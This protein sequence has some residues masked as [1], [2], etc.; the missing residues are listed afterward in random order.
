M[1]VITMWQPWASLLACGAKQYETRSWATNY[2][3]PI[4]IH[5]G[6]RNP[7]K[8]ITQISL[9][10]SAYEALGRT[11]FSDL[12]R[13]AVIAM[14]EL[15]GC[16]LIGVDAMGTYIAPKS[17]ATGIYVKSVYI[18]NENELLFGDWMPGRYAWEFANM[19]MLPEPIPARGYQGLWNWEGNI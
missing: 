15:V 4:A 16:H 10:N 8:A 7:C 14:A 2:R 13:G 6:L 3:G 9:M 5:A 1:K 17:E 12:P 18:K 11:D 19:T